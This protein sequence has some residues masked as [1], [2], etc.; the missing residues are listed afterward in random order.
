M[1]TCCGYTLERGTKGSTAEHLS[2][3]EYKLQKIAEQLAELQGQVEE[4]KATYNDFMN[5]IETLSIIE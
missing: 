4:V 1:R 2:V 5:V 3:E